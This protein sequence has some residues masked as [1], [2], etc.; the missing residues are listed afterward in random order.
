MATIRRKRAGMQQERGPDM[1]GL[2]T[3]SDEILMDLRVGLWPKRS[4]LRDVVAPD[5][6]GWKS[7]NP[8]SLCT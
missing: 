8:V 7:G 4:V 2:R 3:N 5:T 1:Q 6:M